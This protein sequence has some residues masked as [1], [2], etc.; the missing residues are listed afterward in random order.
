[1]R[2][3]SFGKY[4][5]LT[6]FGESHGKAIGLVLEDVKPGITFP[7]DEI[8]KE[9]AKRKPGS[10]DFSSS[11]QETDKF[12]VLSGV[13]EGK[14]TGMPICILVYNKDYRTRDYQKIKDIF[15]PGHADFSYCKKFK[16]YD[17]RGGGR[18]SGRETIS[19]VA[20]GS[21]LNY[22]IKDININ[23]FPIQIGK[24]KVNNID[25]NL[26]NDLYW[27]DKYNYE[28][29]TKYLHKIKKSGDSVG[30]I[31]H[32]TID[33]IRSG[34][35]DPVFEKLDA[36]LAKA[37]LSI[38]SVK[39]IEFGKGFK[40]AYLKGS[41][42]NDNIT[43]DGFETNNAGGILGGISNGENIEFNFVVKPTPSIGKTQTTVSKNGFKKEITIEGRHDTCIIPRLLPVAKAMVKLVLADAISYQNLLEKKEKNLIEFRETYDKID[44]D[45]LIAL[46]K[47][48][49]ISQ[50]VSNYKHKKD[51]SIHDENRENFL[52]ENIQKKAHLLGLDKEMVNKLWKIIL[53]F[54]K[55]EQLK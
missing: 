26:K 10:G 33:N 31:V 46:Y 32:V 11:R 24:Y 41:Q 29:L 50:K 5:G 28:N 8:S 22:L 2:A 45:I 13:F 23:V 47:R 15:R 37:I 38:G 19:R 42:A 25:L 36:N 17:Y 4:F 1:M 51:L 55:K 14:T 12:Q 30:G 44:E 18:A 39:G 27:P 6:T 9:L 43:P 48:M 40:F 16:I 7:F 54:S 3:N 53:K 20:A 34:L 49:K 21:I 35:G 52:L